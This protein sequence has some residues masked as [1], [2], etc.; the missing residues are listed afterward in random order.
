M[1][2]KSLGSLAQMVRSAS[3]SVSRDGTAD[4]ASTDA[5]NDHRHRRF[6]A[7]M[8]RTLLFSAIVLGG[9]ATVVVALA[10]ATFV[11]RRV[12]AGRLLPGVHVTG[13]SSAGHDEQFVQDEVTRLGAQ[14][15]AAAVRVRIGDQELS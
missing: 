13:V 7:S 8:P 4:P 9:L 14:L 15:A 11:E 1:R 3:P 5:P 6:A 12:Y 2:K 10:I